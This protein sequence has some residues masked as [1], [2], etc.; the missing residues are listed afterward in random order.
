MLP[1]PKPDAKA[2]PNYPVS[3]WVCGFLYALVALGAAA[4]TACTLGK[5]FVPADW[6]P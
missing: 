4:V 1:K 2:P 6:L 5:L 3:R